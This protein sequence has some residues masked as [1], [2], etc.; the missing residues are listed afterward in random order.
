MVEGHGRGQIVFLALTALTS[1]G[2]LFVGLALRRA[3]IRENRVSQFQIAADALAR[4]V[5]ENTTLQPSEVGVNIW[6]VKGAFGFRQLV[7]QAKVADHRNPTPITWTKGKGIIGEAWAKNRPR[8]WDLE[9]IRAINPTEKLGVSL[10]RRSVGSSA[11]MSS[12]GRS[13]TVRFSPFHSGAVA[14]SG[15][16]CVVSAVDALVPGKTQEL[17]DF[18]KTPAFSSVWATCEAAFAGSPRGMG[19]SSMNGNGNG[20][21]SSAPPKVAVENLRRRMREAVRELPETPRGKLTPDDVTTLREAGLVELA[22]VAEI[23]A[24]T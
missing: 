1:L 7:R 8:V 19:R 21:S 22:E 3:L 13:V 6:L 24:E 9:Y 12:T 14:S 16:A 2:A 17:Q 20:K 5:W 15:T 18:H 10:N 11:G 4:L 23:Y